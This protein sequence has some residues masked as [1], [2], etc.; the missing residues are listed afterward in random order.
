MTNL[1]LAAALTMSPKVAS[2][3]PR[4]QAVAQPPITVTVK[5]VNPAPPPPLASN[6][7]AVTP[8]AGGSTTYF[9]LPATNKLRLGQ[10]QVTAQ[11]N[12]VSIMVAAIGADGL[13]SAFAGPVT[14][15]IPL[16]PPPL[17]NVQ[18]IVPMFSADLLNWQKQTNQAWKFTTPGYWKLLTATNL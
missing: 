10:A 16:P 7:V 1:L 2:Q 8:L 13:Q 18:W 12:S 14:N 6:L 17:T 9:A 5:W 11:S 15:Q 3:Q 4:I